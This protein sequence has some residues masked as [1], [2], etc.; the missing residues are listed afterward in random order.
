MSCRA[1]LIVSEMYVDL[2]LP[3]DM[4]LEPF[5]GNV[6]ANGGAIMAFLNNSGLLLQSETWLINACLRTRV[7][8]S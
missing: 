5:P 4:L 6:A 7:N 3:A 8:L 2:Q 1:P